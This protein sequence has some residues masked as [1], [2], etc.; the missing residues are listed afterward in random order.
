MIKTT[1]ITDARVKGLDDMTT[2]ET[3]ERRV[4]VEIH[5]DASAENPMDEN[6]LG[7][8]IL[9]AQR[10]YRGTG[11][12]SIHEQM[13]G[14]SWAVRVD[15]PTSYAD[16]SAP[17]GIVFISPDRI[18]EEYGEDTPEIRER[19]RGYL[20]GEAEQ[21]RAWADGYNFGYTVRR[22]VKC[23]DCG[24]WEEYGERD[25]LYGF[26]T[27]DEKDLID[28]MGENMGDESERAALALAVENW[29]GGIGV[30]GR[31]VADAIA[32][33]EGE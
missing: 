26:T 3:R 27:Y 4:I 28:W 12:G 2:A 5:Y 19:V 15:L 25:A 29:V 9:D 13:R 22:E 24:Q 21:Y 31:G 33:V 17:S 23:G 6:P 14:E 20:A 8:L 30:C 11:D 1:T 7:T 32:N 10:N 18:R 16:R